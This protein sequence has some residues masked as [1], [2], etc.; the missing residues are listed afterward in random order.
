MAPKDVWRL[1]YRTQPLNPN[2]APAAGEV[3]LGHLDIAWRTAMGETGHLL[4][5]PCE[6]NVGPWFFMII[7]SQDVIFLKILGCLHFLLSYLSMSGRFSS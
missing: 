3:K 6:S 4:T 2:T 1:L 7:L 5:F